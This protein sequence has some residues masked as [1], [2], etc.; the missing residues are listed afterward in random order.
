VNLLTAFIMFFLAGF[1]GRALTPSIIRS[2]EPGKQ[3][4]AER[5]LRYSS[6]MLFAAALLCGIGILLEKA[7][8]K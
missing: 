6:T 2:I 4:R 5:E 1:I 7:L 3:G 8:A